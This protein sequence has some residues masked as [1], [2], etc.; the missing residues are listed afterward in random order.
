MKTRMMI[1]LSSLLLGLTVVGCAAQVAGESDEDDVE[2]AEQGLAFNCVGQCVDLYRAC[3]A[4]TKNYSACAAER[5]ACKDECYANT[6]EPGD[7]N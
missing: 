3:V 6:C 1:A 2:Q 5:E 7:P 4:A